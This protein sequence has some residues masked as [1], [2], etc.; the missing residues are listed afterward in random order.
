VSVKTFFKNLKWSLLDH[1]PELR[2]ARTWEQHLA[3]GLRLELRNCPACNGPWLAH[4][5]ASIASIRIG[6]DRAAA[7]QFS[8]LVSA[9]RWEEVVKNQSGKH[10]PDNAEMCLIRCSDGRL[11]QLSV[12]T[13]FEP[14][15]YKS[16]DYCE[17]LDSGDAQRLMQLVPKIS[18]TPLGV[19]EASHEMAV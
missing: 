3:A 5:Y 11:A 7:A 16:I 4:S 19:G 9:H 14:W 6:H 8:E 12:H 2:A 15:D 17:V 18:W 1:Y 10:D 13:P